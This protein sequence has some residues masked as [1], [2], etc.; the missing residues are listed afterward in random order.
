MI[1]QPFLEK[2]LWYLIY[3]LTYTGHLLHA[4]NNLV[5][6]V[7]PENIFISE[8]GDIK[9]STL[10]TFYDEDLNFNKTLIMK[11]ITLLSPE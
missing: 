11:E 5:G 10:Y 1:N 2:E 4:D 3:T 9:C 6:D 7:R 8:D